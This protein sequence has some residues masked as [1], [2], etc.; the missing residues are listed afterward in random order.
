MFVCWVTFFCFS[1][2]FVLVCFWCE[3]KG[4]LN[5]LFFFS[6]LFFFFFFSFFSTFFFLFFFF[7]FFLR[8]GVGGCLFVCCCCNLGWGGGEWSVVVIVLE[9]FLF[10][11]NYYYYYYFIYLF[12]CLCFVLFSTINGWLISLIDRFHMALFSAREQTHCDL[13]ICDY[14]RVNVALHRVFEYPPK[15]FNYLQR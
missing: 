11:S 12:F 4:V 1:F 10:F 8:G 13:A 5:I 14:V 6:F 15:R 7:F 3:Y 9:Y 2:S